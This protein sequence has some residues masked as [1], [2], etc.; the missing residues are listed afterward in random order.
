MPNPAPKLLLCA[1]MAQRAAASRMG[2]QTCAERGQP[3]RGVHERTRRQLG[4]RRVSRHDAGRAGE[5]GGAPT[6]GGGEGG[7]N[8]SHR[9][10]CAR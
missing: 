2:K 9:P 10:A 7:V 1:A 3:E 8:S 5:G 6:T 4:Q